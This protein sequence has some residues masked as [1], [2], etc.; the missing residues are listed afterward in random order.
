M[1]DFENHHA[2]NGFSCK[3]WRGERMTLI[4]FD[5]ADP[6]D[7]LVGFAIEV[8]SPHRN[9]FAPLRNRIAFSYPEPAVNAVD[10]N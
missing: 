1:S 3:L 6:E 7:D 10:G 4:G 8:K 2:Q 5:V 9:D